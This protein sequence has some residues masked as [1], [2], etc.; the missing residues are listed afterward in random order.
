MEGYWILL[1]MM[2]YTGS[3]Y[4]YLLPNDTHA[5]TIEMK[6]ELFNIPQIIEDQRL[7]KEG[8]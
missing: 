3:A 6:C 5:T 1:D 8:I 2:Y 4:D 7:L